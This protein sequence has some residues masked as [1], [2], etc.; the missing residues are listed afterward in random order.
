MTPP[1]AGRPRTTRRSARAGLRPRRPAHGP[2]V[3]GPHFANLGRVSRPEEQAAAI[4]FPA[5]G[6]YARAVALGRK[7]SS[8]DSS[9]HLL[10]R[11]WNAKAPWG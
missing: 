8:M 9:R 7:A 3:L 5:A 11:L 6:V 2:A 4:L 10:K 1:P